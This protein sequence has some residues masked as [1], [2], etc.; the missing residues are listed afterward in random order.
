MHDRDEITESLLLHDVRGR[1]FGLNEAGHRIHLRCGVQ[2]EF[3]QAGAEIAQARFALGR[4]GKPVLRAFAV[5]GE[6]ELAL[7]AIVR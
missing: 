4:S 1:P 2:E 7:P 6:Q 3:L 5:T